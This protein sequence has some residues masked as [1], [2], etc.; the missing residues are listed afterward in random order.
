MILYNLIVELR[1]EST[2]VY[3]KHG[4]ALPVNVTCIEK[5]FAVTQKFETVDVKIFDPTCTRCFN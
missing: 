2:N 5:V 4:K 1:N 3:A